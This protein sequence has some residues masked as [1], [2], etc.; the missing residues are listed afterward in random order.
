[1]FILTLFMGPVGL[2]EEG[3]KLTSPGST[4]AWISGSQAQVPRTG[5][6]YFPSLGAGTPRN[7]LQLEGG[8]RVSGTEFSECQVILKGKRNHRRHSPVLPAWG[9]GSPSGPLLSHI[10]EPGPHW[11]LPPLA[12]HR[13]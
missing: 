1:M 6:S 12:T 9:R 7:V 11:F 10:P 2:K 8:T 13:S 5:R 3:S 4:D